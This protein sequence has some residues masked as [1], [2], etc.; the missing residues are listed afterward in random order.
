MTHASFLRYF[1]ALTVA[2]SAALTLSAQ[3]LPV[4]SDLQ[5]WLKAD[6]GVTLDGGGGVTQ[7]DDQSGNGNHAIQSTASLAPTVLANALNNKP[8][9]HFDGVDDYLSVASSPSVSFTGDLT[10][11]FVVRFTDFSNYRAVWAKTANNFPAPTDYYILP[12][13]GRPQVYRGSGTGAGLGSFASSVALTAGSYMTVGFGIEGTT[14]AHFLAGN[15]A[16]SGSISVPT[17]DTGAPLL[18][19]TRGDLFTKMKGEIAEIVIYSRALTPAERASVAD[20][21]AQKYGIVNLLPTISLNVTP[22]GPTHA[23]GE[24]LTLTAT[25]S[26]PDGTV[27]N[28][29]FFANGA[30]L[31]TATAPPY[32]LRVTLDTPGSYT[33]TAR[34]TDNKD[35]T[36]DSTPVTRTVNPAPPPALGVTASLQMWLKADA[37]VTVGLGGGVLSWEDQSGK[38]NHA[39]SQLESMAPTVAPAAINSLPALRFDGVDDRLDVADSPSIS[40]TGDLTTFFVVKMDDFATFRAVWAK[41][42]GPSGNL[43]APTDFYAVPGSGLPKVYRGDGTANSIGFVDGLRALHAGQFDLVGFS[44][45]S[46]GLTHFLNGSANGTGL[47]P[48]G[49]A[50]ADTPLYIGT[51]HDQFTRLKGDLAEVLIYDTA[52]TTAELRNVQTYLAA[53]YGMPLAS[54]IN[55]LPTATITA[56]TAGTVVV[57]PA[58]VVL[59]ADAADSDGSVVQVDFLVNGGVAATD[60]T[61]PYS[62]TVTFPMASSASIQARVIDNLG[63]ISL[64]APVT[65]TVDQTAPVPIP[66]LSNLRLWLRADKGVTEAGGA[67]SAWNDQS[68]NFNNPIQ[69][70]PAR[71][72]VLVDNVLNGE[73]VLRFDGLDDSLV[74]P[75]S[76]T[77]AITG[78]ITT[79]FVVNF[80]DF[81]TFRAVW[82]KTQNN[83]PA[84]T[85]FYT[86]PGTGQPRVFRG[87]GSGS[88]GFSDG[89]NSL[90]AGTFAIVAFDQSGTT[91]HHYLNGQPNGDGT[92][93]AALGD[94]GAPLHIG[95]R[96]DQFTRM[97]G[98]IAEI[99][100]YDA[101]LSEE[102]RTT[103]FNYLGRRY[104]IATT[105]VLSIANNG[106]GTVTVSWP[107]DVTG[108]ELEQASDLPG[109]WTPITF[110]VVNNQFIDFMGERAFYRL[111]KQ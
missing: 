15:V 32:R 23:P 68:G 21:L 45:A 93:T 104:G 80:V 83:L 46:G 100:I 14:C 25:A 91:L 72:P 105:P 5:L 67:V 31:G 4:T 33:L 35:G 12:G 89:L 111:R 81:D 44:I 62:A 76:P 54:A 69:T 7:W 87:N 38:A 59:S 101:A 2:I 102:E 66:A 88:A 27:A 47:V 19:G 95:T 24:E 17:A 55:T 78:D 36:A 6:A 52:L 13:S 28:V 75:S 64:S 26:D 70:D 43:P 58:N 39:T 18:I 86:L 79:F 96:G 11:F 20:Y 29:S 41:T 82:A 92:I 40:I 61:A 71:R 22:A 42:A 103:V 30:L 77:V 110:G 37:G 99:I 10:T 3:N 1:L 97:K 63:G 106:D 8:V 65:I 57:A 94:T 73:P 9:L 50:D 90:V 56:P 98:D 49:T 109:P 53:R 16:S 108:W 84:S 51:R 34:V 60:T 85:D 48:T 107:S 74:A